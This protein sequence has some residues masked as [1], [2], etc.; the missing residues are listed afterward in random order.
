MEMMHLSQSD[1]KESDILLFEAQVITF[2]L[3]LG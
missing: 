3:D 1:V 2:T